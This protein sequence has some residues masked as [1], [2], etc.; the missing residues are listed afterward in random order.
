MNLQKYMQDL[1]NYQYVQGDAE[2]SFLPPA[3]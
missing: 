2:D 1:M 3:A